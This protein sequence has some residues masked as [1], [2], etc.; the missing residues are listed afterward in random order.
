[1]INYNQFKKIK[2][3]QQIGTSQ[4]KISKKL[5]VSLGSVR[6]WWRR[7]EK[8]FLSLE[9]QKTHSMEPYRAFILEN[10][11]FCPQIRQTNLY[12]K[13]QENFPDFK[14]SEN[15][16]CRYVKKLREEFGLEQFTKRLTSARS[17][18][19]PGEEAQVDFGEMRVKTMYG[20]KVKVYFFCMVLN[21]SNFRFVYFEPKPF[22]TE[23]AIRAHNFAFRFFGSVRPQKILYDLDNVFAHSENYGDIIFIQRFVD[24]VK[25]IGFQVVCCHTHDPQSKSVVENS[26]KKIKYGFLEGFEYTGCQSINAA[27]LRW[28]DTD[29][30][31]YITGSRRGVPR[32]LF[33]EE[34]RH[35][36][37]VAGHLLKPKQKIFSG[38]HNNTLKYEGKEYELPLGANLIM[39]QVQAEESN[40][41]LS[42]YC[43]ET[44]DEICRHKISKDKNEFVV[45]LGQTQQELVQ[46]NKIRRQF[47]G[48]DLFERFFNR[49]KQQINRYLAKQCM[50]ILKATQ[51]YSIESLHEAFEHCLN[52]DICTFTQMMAFLIMK[53]GKEI[54]KKFLSK[55]KVAHYIKVAKELEVLKD[56]E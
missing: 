34:Q 36:V 45:K 14:V 6:Y 49:L 3:L 54:P 33:L 16:F 46:V 53:H 38:L 17:T 35:L 23:T 52:V 28:L 26:I 4:N 9:A 12:Y 22:T 47:K 50:A 31:A 18:T 39:K 51:F 19:A 11:Q 27:V 2:E 8:E 7:T 32:D 25:T 41:E 1:M 30:N 55:S 20:T 29:G 10:L 15:T 40:G 42:I 43:T 5:E 44:G 48:D 37:Q 24:Y 13:L 56:G 21:Y